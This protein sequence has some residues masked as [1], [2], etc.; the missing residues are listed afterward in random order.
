MSKGTASQ[1]KHSKGKTHIMCRRCGGHTYHK[2]K[3]VCSSCGYG[4]GPK[5]RTYT[6]TK[7]K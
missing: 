4:N 2:T 3:K 7:S 1:G 6:F 5:M